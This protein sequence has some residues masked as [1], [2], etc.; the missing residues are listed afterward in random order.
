MIDRDALHDVL[1]KLDFRHHFYRCSNTATSD[2]IPNK[3]SLAA[4]HECAP[5]SVERFSGK[6]RGDE[7]GILNSI[8]VESDSGSN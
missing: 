6:E 3:I 7:F 5:V 2:P 4:A 8:W 1:L